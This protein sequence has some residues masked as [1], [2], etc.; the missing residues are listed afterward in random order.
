[1]WPNTLLSDLL[2]IEHPILQ[3]PMA[4]FT[5]VELVAAKLMQTLVEEAQDLI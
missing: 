3:A 2:G 5:T 1:M 4:G